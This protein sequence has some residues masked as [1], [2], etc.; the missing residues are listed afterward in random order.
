MNSFEFTSSLHFEDNNINCKMHIAISL[1]TNGIQMYI[2]PRT[3]LGH[4]Y[5]PKNLKDGSSLGAE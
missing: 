2:H 4:I 5:W 3:I 1:K